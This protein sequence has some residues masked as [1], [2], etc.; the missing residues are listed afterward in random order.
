MFITWRRMCLCVCDIT[1]YVTS[2]SN[3]NV[4]VE[5]MKMRLEKEYN[6][7][8]MF[9]PKDNIDLFMDADFWPIGIAYRRFVEFRNKTDIRVSEIITNNSTCRQP[10]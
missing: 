4:T 8:K 3:L 10:K 5:M 9:V 7:F 1:K 6:S 2:K